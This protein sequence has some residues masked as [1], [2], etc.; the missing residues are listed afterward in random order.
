MYAGTHL[1]HCDREDGVA[2]T[3]ETS[4]VST[5]TRCNTPRTELSTIF[6]H[7]ETEISEFGKFRQVL[8]KLSCIICHGNPEG[9]VC[10][11]HADGQTDGHTEANVRFSQVFF[12][13]KRAK[14]ITK[15]CLSRAHAYVRGSVHG[16]RFSENDIVTV[17]YW[18]IYIFP[19]LVFL[20]CVTSWMSCVYMHVQAYL[21][22]LRYAG[23]VFFTNR[24]SSIFE[25]QVLLFKKY[26]LLPS[27]AALVKTKAPHFI[28]THC[29]LYRHALAAGTFQ[30]PWE[31]FCQQPFKSS[32]LSD[33]CLWI[34]TFLRHSVKKWERNMKCFSTT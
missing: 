28:V 1:K 10:I 25:F 19:F 22:A 5:F 16:K 21:V 9:G 3:S 23:I 2:Y 6:N 18:S 34:I 13:C 15:F 14:N 11:F 30:Q 17:P 31:K 24:R 4:A 29:F 12:F 7:R 20:A 8:V 33:A 32:I 26:I 27:F